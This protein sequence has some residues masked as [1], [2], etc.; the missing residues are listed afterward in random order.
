[1]MDRT[2]FGAAI[3]GMVLLAGP[4]WAAQSECD[5]ASKRS[6]WPTALLSC[7]HLAR[8]GDAPAQLILGTMH[9]RGQGVPVNPA[10]AARWYRRAAEQ[11]HTVAQTELGVMYAAGIGV[12]QDYG[13]AHMWL[14]LA[15]SAPVGGRRAAD[16]RDLIERSMLP[17]EIT[18]ARNRAEAWKDTHGRSQ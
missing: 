16:K 2:A 7:E 4:A 14:N 5:A 3:I 11:G 8:R 13:L 15:A 1:M 6:D 17:V 10:E 9:L 12:R 18:K